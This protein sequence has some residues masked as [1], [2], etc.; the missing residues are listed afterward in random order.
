MSSEF[1]VCDRCSDT[2]RP[3]GTNL[4]VWQKGRTTTIWQS[5]SSLGLT[6]WAARSDLGNNNNKNPNRYNR[7]S[8]LRAWTPNDSTG[9]LMAKLSV[10]RAC[11]KFCRR[12]SS[13]LPALT[14]ISQERKVNRKQ[15]W[16]VVLKFHKYLFNCESSVLMIFPQAKSQQTVA[17]TRVRHVNDCWPEEGQGWIPRLSVSAD[18]KSDLPRQ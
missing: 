10:S 5:F 9:P 11:L 3:I 18:P 15:F 14:W 8:A 4:W 7:V 17:G 1:C 2:Y 6:V 16:N 13:R 12:L